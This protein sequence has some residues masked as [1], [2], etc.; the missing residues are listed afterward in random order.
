MTVLLRRVRRDCPSC[1]TPW[2][3][4]THLGDTRIRSNCLHTCRIA[5]AF[6]LAGGQRRATFEP[7]PTDDQP[8]GGTMTR[9]Q[10]IEAAARALAAQA[11]FATQPWDEMPTYLRDG[12]QRAAEA[13]TDAVLPLIADAIKEQAKSECGERASRRQDPEFWADQDART[14]AWG[15][16]V[17][18]HYPDGRPGY[19]CEGCDAAE[20][21]DYATLAASKLV[22]SLGGAS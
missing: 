1:H 18:V 5:R 9:D 14:L 6:A 3:V 4:A 12:Y 17:S 11:A 20:S 15:G 13:S 2:T 8:P 19:P 22:S 16:E 7:L 21:A 10:L